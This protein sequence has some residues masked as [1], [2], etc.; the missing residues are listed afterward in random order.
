VSRIL[1]TG[2][3]AHVEYKA[4]LKLA[5]VFLDTF[6]YNCGSTNNDVINANLPIVTRS[7]L[8]LVSRMG[9]SLMNKID[10]QELISNSTDEYIKCCINLYNNNEELMS[11]IKKKMNFHFFVNIKTEN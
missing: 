3:S 2:R 1:F 11:K 8:S 4:K 10:I 5:D 9:G 7:G 6:P